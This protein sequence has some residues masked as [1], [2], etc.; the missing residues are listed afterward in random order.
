MSLRYIKKTLMKGKGLQTRRLKRD[1]P[2]RYYR[3]VSVYTG[4]GLRARKAG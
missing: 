1:K 4:P 2:I 3:L